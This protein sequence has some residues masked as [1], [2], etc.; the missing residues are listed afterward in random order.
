MG[1][2]LLTRGEVSAHGRVEISWPAAATPITVDTPQPL[3]QASK[4]DRMT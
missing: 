1:V 3:W 4:A 2:L